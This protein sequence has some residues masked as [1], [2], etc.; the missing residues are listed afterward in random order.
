MIVE[1]IEDNFSVQSF[2]WV[3][4]LVINICV[5]IQVIVSGVRTHD[6]SLFPFFLIGIRC[7]YYRL[8]SINSLIRFS[9]FGGHIG[10]DSISLE[11][12][13]WTQFGTHSIDDQNRR[14]R[15]HQWRRSAR[16]STT[17][18]HQT[19]HSDDDSDR[20]EL[21]RAQQELPLDCDGRSHH[22]YCCSSSDSIEPDLP[23]IYWVWAAVI[24]S[25]LFQR[26]HSS[27]RISEVYRGF[28]YARVESK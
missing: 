27:F 21:L 22:F 16:L 28:G 18:N 25:D 6:F 11:W 13:L 7:A 23:G 4:S 1:G 20:L 17:G 5:K 2:L 12:D 9:L 3:F 14:E 15:W 26:C 24:D 8:N 10:V 19:E